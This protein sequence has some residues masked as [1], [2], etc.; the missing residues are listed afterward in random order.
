[1]RLLPRSRTRR[2]CDT[3]HLK[4][5]RN[6]ALQRMGN[7]S[8]IHTSYICL[9][10]L[11]SNGRN[12]MAR[13]AFIEDRRHFVAIRRRISICCSTTKTTAVRPASRERKKRRRAKDAKE[14]S[15]SLASCC[16]VVPSECSCRCFDLC[17]RSSSSST[18]LW[19]ANPSFRRVGRRRLSLTIVRSSWK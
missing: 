13:I 12:T 2:A 9:H 10:R 4:S 8:T 18:R 14:P 6:F 5:L 1:M 11:R 16:F 3:L 17:C 19:L 15:S 7:P